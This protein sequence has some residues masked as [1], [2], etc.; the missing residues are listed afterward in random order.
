M[1]TLISVLKGNIVEISFKRTMKIW[2]KKNL[3]PNWGKSCSPVQPVQ[4]LV[5]SLTF[6]NPVMFSCFNHKRVFVSHFF[7]GQEREVI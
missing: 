5:Q 6:F 2:K 3:L 1:I 4:P 7:K